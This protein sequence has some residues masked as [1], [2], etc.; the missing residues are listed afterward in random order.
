MIVYDDD[1]IL[2]TNIENGKL[3]NDIYDIGYNNRRIQC[4]G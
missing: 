4:S 2:Y 1:D 3:D